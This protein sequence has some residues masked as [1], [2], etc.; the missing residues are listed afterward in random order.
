[1]AEKALTSYSYQ[2]YLD[3][4]ASSS[5]KYE[6]HG[7]FI[8]AM[9]GGTLAHGQI[10]V[11]TAYCVSDE[12]AKANK[13][14][15]SYSSDIKV[16]IETADRTFYPDF[17]VVCGEVLTAEKDP[18]ALIN[19]LLILEVLSESTVAFDRGAKFSHYRQISSLKEYVLVSQHEAMVDVFYRTKDGTWEI[20]TYTNLED[21]VQ[22]KSLDCSISM[23]AVY[24]RVPGI[25]EQVS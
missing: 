3:L 12:I 19:P 22:L 18:N 4:E 14:C 15:N 21:S 8:T 17:S 24:R 13:P 16:R 7:G 23:A 1:M 6:F 10:A 9:S 25:D 5:T 20:H 2:K 11:N